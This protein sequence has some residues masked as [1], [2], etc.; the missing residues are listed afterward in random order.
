MNYRDGTTKLVATGTLVADS[1][2]SISLEDQQ[3]DGVE[4]L[5]WKIPYPCILRV[6]ESD[7]APTSV[8]EK[9]TQPPSF[10]RR[11]PRVSARQPVVLSWQE[12]ELEHVESTFT[13]SISRFGCALRSHRFFRPGTR[14][15]L[16]HQGRTI[17]GRVVYSLKD[18]STN[19]VEVGVGFDRDGGEFWQVEF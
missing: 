8:Y 6:V 2:G 10:R 3:P 16:E 5:R 17:E 12:D 13:L 9:T 7:S 11:S 1:S 19:L 4:V 18:H 15:R 14:V